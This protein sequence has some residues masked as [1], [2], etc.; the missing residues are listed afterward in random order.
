MIRLLPFILLFSFHYGYATSHIDTKIKEA[1]TQIKNF[2][3]KYSNINQKMAQNARAIL[4]QQ[5]SLLKQQ[6]KLASLSTELKFKE[7][8]QRLDRK[9][10]EK[11]KKS[12]QTLLKEQTQVESLLIDL[13][14][15]NI[16]LSLLIDDQVDVTPEALMTEEVLK[17]LS[18]QTQK[19]IKSFNKNYSKINKEVD[20][21]NR[22]TEILRI[23]IEKIDIKRKKMLQTKNKL[24]KALFQLKKD[25]KKYN[26]RLRKVLKQKSSLKSALTQ[27]NIIKEDKKQK[28]KSRQEAEYQRKVLSAKSLPKVKSHSS[29]YNKIKTKRYRGK[30]TIAPL[31]KYSVTKKFGTYIDPIYKIR[32]YNESISLKPKYSNAKVKTVFNGKIVMAKSTPLLDNVVIVEHANNLHTI[33]AHLDKIAPGIKRGK[34]I[35]KGSV[36]GRVSNELM[37]EVTQKNYHINPLQLIK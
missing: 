14:A 7:N 27:L 12:Q 24:E 3:K 36:I 5:K 34:R 21:L 28:E 11:L 29:S 4:V 9:E 33:Y 25:K 19:E 10:L 13:I 30:K 22:H 16:S 1:S 26:Q 35:K 32:I 8:K 15:R 20:T 23:S 31:D 6:K 18:R 17:A 37:F 2:D